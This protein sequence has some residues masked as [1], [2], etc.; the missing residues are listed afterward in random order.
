MNGN[1]HATTEISAGAA[2]AQLAMMLAGA[3]DER[4]AGFSV[5][6]LARMYRVKPKMIALMLAQARERRA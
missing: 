5:D 2:R 6:T 1:R 3:T 4:L